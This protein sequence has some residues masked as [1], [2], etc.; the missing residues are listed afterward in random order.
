MPE[1]TQ[2][3]TEEL[4][5]R[6]APNS[7]RE[8]AE[9]AHAAV[10][11]AEYSD[12]PALVDPIQMMNAIRGSE[13]WPILE[14]GCTDPV[15]YERRHT[16]AKHVVGR[17]RM[18]GHPV[19]AACGWMFSG[20]PE[21]ESFRVNKQSEPAFWEAAG[22][23]RVPGKGTWYDRITELETM[24]AGIEQATTFCWEVAQ[25][26]DRRIGRHYHVDGA[27]YETH[28]RWLHAC[29]DLEL[30]R[31]LRE[32]EQVPEYLERASAK[33]IEADR[34][35][36]H[37]EAVESDGP[38]V[39]NGPPSPP[40]D[41]EEDAV[42]ANEEAQQP[43]HPKYRKRP[44]PRTPGEPR[45]IWQ[46]G[47]RYVCRDGDAGYRTMG[48]DARRGQ[49]RRKKKGWSGGIAMQVTEDVLGIAPC[50][51][52]NP[53]DVNEHLVLEDL[54]CKQMRITHR[55]PEAYVGDRGAT[56]TRTK[57]RFNELGI[58]L[59]TPHRKQNQEMTDRERLR[60]DTH[61]E[62]GF[63]VCEHCGGATRR[64]GTEVRNGRMVAVFRCVDPLTRRCE[65]AVQR[66]P[67]EAEPLLFGQVARDE[68]LYFELRGG[69]NKNRENVHALARIRH[70]TVGD[71]LP[72]RCKR[73]GIA[74]QD[75]RA[76]L[77]CF[78][79]IFRVCLRFG[80]LGNWPRVKAMDRPPPQRHQR[81]PGPPQAPREQGSAAAARPEGRG[82]R[83]HLQRRAAGRLEADQRA[84]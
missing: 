77:A 1:R 62:Y 3:N 34:A 30:C 45:V 8:R 46:N 81:C 80:W 12:D 42:Q 79:D 22:Y 18:E 53:A 27:A 7:S 55:I 41:L 51:L 37:K 26:N 52:H 60:T 10:A 29:E 82:A 13:V 17:N 6:F 36:R 9:H 73:V 71:S 21:I 67:C 20:R 16:G 28:A 35:Q 69:T 24:V 58:A 40:D 50:V 2:G 64:T 56:I 31:A 65:T 43:Q 47:H 33:D 83:A 39:R 74:H 48:G 32:L 78:L 84:P 19:L 54:L 63:K 59:L 61:D 15:E 72:I 5:A 11:P 70:A 23:S 75:L 38:A 49:Q 57:E 14:R 76:A 68:E 44:N 4:M 66:V 25:R